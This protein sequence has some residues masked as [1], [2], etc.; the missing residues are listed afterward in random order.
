MLSQPN[1]MATRQRVG[2]CRWLIR[3]RNTSALDAIVT[4]QWEDVNVN[5]VMCTVT[6]TRRH[7]R[8]LWV[9]SPHRG[10][11]SHTCMLFW[12]IIT[13][14]KLIAV[15]REHNQTISLHWPVWMIEKR[16]FWQLEFFYYWLIYILYIYTVTYK[17]MKA[18]V[19]PGATEYN[20]LHNMTLQHT[21][22]IGFSSR[23]TIHWIWHLS[24][25]LC[26]VLERSTSR[27][28]LVKLGRRASVST[29]AQGAPSPRLPLLPRWPMHIDL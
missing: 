28:S 25:L 3:H 26:L 7:L 14:K 9:I 11:S 13:R 19:Q 21:T 27:R 16:H 29:A 22:T 1:T 24:G 17:K 15:V 10:A 5:T 6:N 18:L 12:S 4:A 2:Y 23:R 8:S 20:P